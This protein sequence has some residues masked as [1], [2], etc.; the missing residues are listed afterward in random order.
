MDNKIKRVAI[1]G[2]VV[3][4]A[5]VA[6]LYIY[7][8]WHLHAERQRLE[9]EAKAGP[10]VQ[11]V[12]ATKTPPE[13]VLTLVGEARPFAS[14]TLYAKVSGYLKTVKVDKGDKVK[15][16][17]VLAVIESPEIDKEYQGAFAE[18]RNKKAIAGRMNT[19]RERQLVSPQE[20]D[21]ANSDAEVAGARLESLAVQ[22]G[23]ETLRAP[24]EGTVTSRYADAG[25]LMQNAANSQTSALPVVTVSQVDRLRV[26]T[27]VDQRDAAYIQVGSPAKV[28][29]SERPDLE[30]QAT[31]SRVSGE[32]DPKTK[33]L[34]TEVDMDNHAGQI[35]P[36]S[37]VQ[38]TL[39]VKTPE[40][41]QL[42]V[43]ALVLMQGKPMLPIVGDDDLL[44][45]REVRTGE[46]D[47]QQVSILSGLKEGERVALNI[48][49]GLPDGSHVRPVA[50]EKPK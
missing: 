1:Y 17:Q 49:N 48:S 30:V 33:M 8:F 20:A 28:T 4:V 5:I 37:F 9:E 50:M 10:R 21:Q 16:D 19:L 38:V 3:C 34:L 39:V 41:L 31:V 27:Y 32:L 7:H 13:R 24:F 36:G 25:A 47:G 12:Q 40:A 22:K 29:V 35:V 43:Q 18:A 14:V 11:V 2:G 42:P 44:H 46:N 26:Y 23:Y 45:Y 15:K 6:A